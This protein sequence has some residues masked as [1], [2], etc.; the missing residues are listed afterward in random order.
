MRYITVIFLFLNFLWWTLLLVSLFVSPP[1]LYTR[2]S[3]FFD[4]AFVT[5]TGGNL[6][7]SLLFFTEPSKVMRISSSII[8]LILLIDVIIIFAVG[9]VRHEES[10]V[11]IASVIWAFFIATWTIVADLIVE[12]GK[13]SEE[14]RLTGREETRRTL[15]EWL[16]VLATTVILVVF[17]VICVLMTGTLILRARDVSL[18]APGTR[19]PIEGG[20]Y[21]IHL[22]CVGNVSHTASGARYPT[23]LLEA[24]EHPVKASFE[25]WAHSAM[26][27]GIISRY[28]YWDRP[29]YGWSDNA[30]SP[31]SAGMS[32]TALTEALAI[33]DEKGPWIV[34]AAGYGAI[35]ARVF[36]SVHAKDVVGLLFVDPLHEDLLYRVG[37]AG[38]GFKLWGLGIISPLG[39]K[40][41]PGALFNG[42]SRED[43]VYGISAGQGGKLLKARLQENLVAD[44]L[45]KNEILAAQTIQDNMTPIVVVSSGIECG[46][47]SEWD[48]KQEASTRITKNL[49]DWKIVGGAPHEV[50]TTSKGKNAM[51]KGLEKLM[52]A[53]L[54]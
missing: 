10:P 14:I 29:G 54:K 31:H 25:P 18:A 15:K 2:G 13:R 34:A 9:G 22:A 40:R 50:W 27:N 26:S 38:R 8:A 21:S 48:M 36:A 37:N 24:G 46:R 5:L 44:S 53:T 1:G 32:A 17:I 30:P 41:I 4:F 23:L 47:D 49:I 20:K 43:R 52:E 33:T 39:L 19:I 45:T 11:G 3:G 35:V 42:R 28:C 7:V 51:G 16:A 6:L 12:G